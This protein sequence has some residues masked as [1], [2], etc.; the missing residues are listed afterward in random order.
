MDSCCKSDRMMSY[1]CSQD[2]A[3]F[4]SKSNLLL[5]GDFNAYLPKNFV[6]YVDN[7]AIDNHVP[8]PASQYL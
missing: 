4:I 8:L 1:F 7:D 3:E 5:M 2:C 6:D